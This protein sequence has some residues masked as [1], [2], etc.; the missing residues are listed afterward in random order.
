MSQLQPK[1]IAQAYLQSPTTV[2]ALFGTETN[3]NPIDKQRGIKM[4]IDGEF[5]R[6]TNKSESITAL[7][8][9]SNVKVLILN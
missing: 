6:V 9:L 3:L 4:Y 1:E 7:I 2:P 5:L 8:P